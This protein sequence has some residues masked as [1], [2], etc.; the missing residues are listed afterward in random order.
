MR[1][2]L[3][4]HHRDGEHDNCKD[5]MRE[6]Q[7]ERRVIEQRDD[8]KTSLQR[9]GAGYRNRAPYDLSRSPRIERPSILTR[10]GSSA[11]TASIA[12]ITSVKRVPMSSM[13]QTEMRSAWFVP[14][15]ANRYFF[16]PSPPN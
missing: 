2:P 8:T 10:L 14:R 15:T 7:H 4:V 5:L 9:H 1:Q 11:L 6:R 13:A 16:F 12:D 3:R